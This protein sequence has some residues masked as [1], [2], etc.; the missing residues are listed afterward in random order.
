MFKLHN[1]FINKYKNKKPPFGFNGLGELVY[2]R[3]YSRLKED[4]TNEQW[5]ETIQ[6]VVELIYYLQKQHIKKY[7]LGWEEEKAQESA[8]EMYDLMYNMKFLQSRSLWA[9]TPDLI[10]RNR[11]AALNSCAFVSTENLDK[12]LSKPFEFMMDMSMFGV[13]VGDDTKGENKLTIKPPK[14]SFEY[15][16]PDTREGWVESFKLLLNA[17]F[18]G[19]ALPEFKYHGIRKKG[20]PLKGF[21]GIASGYEPLQRLHARIQHKLFNSIGKKISITDIADIMNRIGVCVIAGNVRRTAQITFGD[22]NSE[23]FI[24]LKDYEYTGNDANGNPIYKGS[25]AERGSFGWVSNNSVTCKVGQTYDKLATQTAVNGEPGY[26]WLENAQDYSRMNGIKDFKDHRATG[27]NPCLEQTLESY[28]M[29]NLVEVFPT[30]HE[31]KEEFL[32]TLKFAYLFAKTI[33]LCNTHWPETNR[34]MLRNRRIGTSV[35]GVAQFIEE[36]GLN[37]LKTWLNE[38]YDIIQQYDEIYSEWFAVPQSIKTTSVKPSG[39]ISL[40]PGVTPGMH[41]PEANHYIRRVNVSKDSNLIDPLRKAGYHIEENITDSSSYIVEIPIEIKGVRP[42]KDVSMWEQ[43][44]LAAF[45]QENWADNQVSC[46]ITFKPE[47]AKDIEK[48]L[49]YFQYKLKGVSFL[50]KTE[51]GAYAQMPYE[52]ISEEKFKELSKNIKPIKFKNITEDSIPV[53][54]CENDTCTIN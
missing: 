45:L 24:K 53:L 9:L 17:Y 50:P 1:N 36:R 46:T 41:Y 31:T 4:G 28:E 12:D 39:T 14:G 48:A 23:E 22:S 7:N 6:R 29:C 35:S 52:E 2:Y 37:E 49:N 10:K 51:K 33:T 32:R 34:V 8:Q 21:G 15:V 20:E 42:L 26:F 30:R 19:E 54:Y 5:Y 3:T 13:G 44:E 40:L 16:I 38:G 27:G 11:L 25:R 18:K 43:L 47:E